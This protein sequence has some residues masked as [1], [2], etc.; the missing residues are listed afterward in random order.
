MA[1]SFS[2]GCR[3]ASSDLYSCISEFQWEQTFTEVCIAKVA[4]G[5]HIKVAPKKQWVTLQERI[6]NIVLDYHTRTTER[7]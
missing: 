2:I 1:Q 6:Q 7:I 5:K 3:K 4:L